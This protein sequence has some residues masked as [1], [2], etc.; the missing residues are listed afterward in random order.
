MPAPSGTWTINAN[1]FKGALSLTPAGQGNLSGKVFGEQLRGF[2]DEGAQKITFIRG[3]N[4]ANPNGVQIYTGYFFGS[5]SPLFPTTPPSPQEE[6]PAS[7]EIRVLAGYFEAFVG[8][9]GTAQRNLFGWMA[10]QN[11]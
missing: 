10:K 7:P 1:G 3:N 2:W 11:V 8:T 5:D 4:P 9:E 6:P